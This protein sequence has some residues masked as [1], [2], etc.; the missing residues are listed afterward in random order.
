[1]VAVR[2]TRLHKIERIVASLVANALRGSRWMAVAGEVLPGSEISAVVL[3]TN[4]GYQ[5]KRCCIQPSHY[6]CLQTCLGSS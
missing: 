3:I 1:M 4:A 2:M 5:K 6:E